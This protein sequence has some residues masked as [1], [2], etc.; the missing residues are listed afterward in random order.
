MKNE[1]RVF[2]PPGT[3]KTTYTARQIRRAVD[4]HGPESVIIS[5]FT[6][7]AAQELA[8]RDLPVGEDRIGTLHA[9]CYR[10]LG[11]PRLAET[12]LGEWN[13]ENPA[14][15]IGRER[16]ADDPWADARGFQMG[17][18]DM[19][20]QK[21]NNLRGRLIPPDAWPSDIQGFHRRWVEWKRSGDFYDFTDLLEVALKDITVA[22]GNP[23]IGF[24]DEVQDFTPLELA[25][26]RLW[27]QSMD[28]FIL[29]GDDDQ[30]LYGFRGSTPR[31]FLEPPLE[32]DHIHVLSQSWRLPRAV[33]EL[34]NKWVHRL[35]YRQEKAFK[36]TDK[37]GE[38]IRSSQ[39][40]YGYPGPLI[41][42]VQAFVDQDKSVMILAPCS[43]M[44]APIVRELKDRG[45]TFHNPW[46]K[47]RPD[48]NPLIPRDK[49][50]TSTVE[51][52]LAFLKP[53][54]KTWGSA[55]DWTRRD[56]ALFSQM[57]RSQNG[58]PLV[59][60]AKKA[61]LVLG[62]ADGRLLATEEDLLRVFTVEGLTSCLDSFSGDRN[63]KWVQDHCVSS[64]RDPIKYPLTV[65]RRQGGRAL[66]ETPRIC[67]GTIHSV[68]GA[69]ADVVF[70]I[71]D[72]SRL[73][74]MEWTGTPVQQD[75]I[76]RQFYV[77]MTRARETLVLC[78][79]ASPLFV[80]L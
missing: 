79:P 80:Q 34:A 39:G 19:A 32:D 17:D 3:G 73:G 6:K 25:L 16:D 78:Q 52:L 59:H 43:Y 22:P 77:G 42:Q 28:H 37:P 11:N 54:G 44:V 56:V 49:R 29:V 69:E 1:R 72:I 31:A 8:G 76:I 10:A 15:S 2:G 21:M 67:V 13:K 4:A 23:Q 5:S 45:L 14:Y 12:Q 71:P 30:C 65:A 60:G 40:N 26:V 63:L 66:R 48:W 53:D 38:V 68:K 55:A 50:S 36:P 41:E 61:A 62:E 75:S 9:H 64:V 57:L 47:K 51:R 20:Y 74:M 27:G 18:G 70:L 35:S 33:Y 58:G 46:R 24:F 7:A